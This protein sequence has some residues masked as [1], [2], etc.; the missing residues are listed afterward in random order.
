M[1]EF[2]LKK[3]LPGFSIDVGLSLGEELLVLFGPS[4][5]GK[6]L[7]LKMLSGIV[8]PDE[9][10]V[11]VARNVVYDSANGVDA[12]IRERRIGY[13]FQDYA[14]FPHMT[15]YGNIAYGMGRAGA[16]PSG[17]VKALLGLMRLEGLEDRFPHEL[18]G[19][20]RQRAALARTLASGPRILL[21]DEPFSALDNQVREKLRNDLVNIHSLYPIT[22]VLVT[23][24]LEEAFMLGDRIAVVN[25]GRIEDLG[26]PEE[27]FYRPGTRNVARFLGVR[28][29]FD[30]R[31]AEVEGSSVVIE[32]PDLGRIRAV[33]AEGSGL[34]PGMEATFCIRPEEITVAVPGEGHDEAHADNV[35]DGVVTASAPRGP[36]HSVYV[37]VGKA[38]IK[39]EVPNSVLGKLSLATGKRVRVSL[40][41]E[42]VWVIP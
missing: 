8:R 39:A 36:S 1:L 28:N 7:I 15:V 25:E 13:V 41:R 14:L 9:G 34:K 3:N 40:K 42:S 30:G 31:V 20:Q 38:S 12:P 4:G 26:A 32:N 17:G 6:S 35:L 33:A 23:H 16:D 22:T 19:G 37:S 11:S 10:M 2:R 24:D 29:I 27:I 5:A 21:L 18:S